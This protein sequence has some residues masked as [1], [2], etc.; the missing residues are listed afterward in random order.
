MQSA[1]KA[2]PPAATPGSPAKRAREANGK[3]E[4]EDEPAS[5][6]KKAEVATPAP[7]AAPKVTTHGSVFHDIV[8]SGHFSQML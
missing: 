8:R 5:K 1:V 7:K 2:P 4:K 3:K 6:K